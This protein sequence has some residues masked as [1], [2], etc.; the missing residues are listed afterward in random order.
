MVEVETRH[1]MF[2]CWMGVGSAIHH[3]ERERISGP[4]ELY[5]NGGL[6]NS[7]IEYTGWVLDSDRCD[8]PY[9]Y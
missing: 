8:E 5:Y 4:G 3:T 1:S 2:G 6:F 7:L 9:Q